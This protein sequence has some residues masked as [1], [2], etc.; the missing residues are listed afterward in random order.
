MTNFQEENF[1]EKLE[2]DEKS[3]KKA[4]RTGFYSVIV[5]QAP[6]NPTIYWM[7]STCGT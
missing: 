6:Q 3:T 4:G 7:E 1:G 5:F 2:N